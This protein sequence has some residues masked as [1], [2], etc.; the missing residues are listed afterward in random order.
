[1][2]KRRPRKAYLKRRVHTYMKG[3][4][5]FYHANLSRHPTHTVP[6]S[7]APTPG[8]VEINQSQ[9][10]EKLWQ[11]DFRQGIDKYNRV[12]VE[13]TPAYKLFRYFSGQS[14]YFVLEDYS[15]HVTQRSIEYKSKEQAEKFY[16]AELIT[17]I[18]CFKT[19]FKPPA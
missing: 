19:S 1:M 15:I 3:G 7:R 2:S 14:N 11:G 17:W 16:R 12:L 8:Q 13:F 4:L 10:L 5:S 18:E 9:Q 6:T